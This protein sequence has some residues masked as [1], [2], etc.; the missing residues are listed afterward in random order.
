MKCG[1]EGGKRAWLGTRAFLPAECWARR[2]GTTSSILRELSTRGRGQCGLGWAGISQA[3]W[4]R[5]CAEG[6][7]ADMGGDET[8]R[9]DET[10]KHIPAGVSAP[11]PRG[12]P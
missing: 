8:S 2:G 11:S 5:G 3:R 4:W 12:K 10:Q 7:Q 9:K 1:V 6:P